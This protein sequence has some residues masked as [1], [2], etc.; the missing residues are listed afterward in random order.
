M[1]DIRTR[2]FDSIGSASYQVQVATYHSLANRLVE[3]HYQTLGWQKAPTVLAGPEH[4]AFVHTVLED[5]DRANWSKSY[6]AIL[7]TA[8]MASELT[9]F[10]LRFH[11]Q[12]NTLADLSRSEIPEWKGLSNFLTRYNAAL[13]ASHRI[14]YGRLL[15]EAVELVESDL[16]ISD[17]YEHVFADE[18]QDSSPVQSRILFGLAKTSRSLT[19]VADPYQ[20]IYSFR[21]TDIHNVLDFPAKASDALGGEADRLVL[22]TSFR[23]PEE[24]LAAAVN[25]TGRELPGAA[26]KVA[27]IRTKRIGCESHIR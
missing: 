27:S 5:E 2:L 25:V 8:A 4:E 22:T 1:N 15:N 13:T 7:G 18:Y 3:A 6:G 20:S 12:N 24:I 21:G 23:V 16:G 26:G 17:A 14:D 19:V 9:D 11:E 10:I